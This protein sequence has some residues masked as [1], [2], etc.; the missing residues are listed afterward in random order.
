MS[1]ALTTPR[2]VVPVPTPWGS[3]RRPSWLWAAQRQS[4]EHPVSGDDDR[5]RYRVTRD[6]LFYRLGFRTGRGWPQ[7]GPASLAG[8]AWFA[9]GRAQVLAG[10]WMAPSPPPPGGHRLTRR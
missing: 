4:A 1:W 8:P 6:W 3:K 9:L 5:H 10:R 7:R 2:G